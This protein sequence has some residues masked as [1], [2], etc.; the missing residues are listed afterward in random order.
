MRCAN[1]VHWLRCQKHQEVST[2]QIAKLTSRKLIKRTWISWR[3]YSRQNQ[4]Y[5]WKIGV[6][7]SKRQ[8]NTN[9]TSLL[10]SNCQ[11][12]LETIRKK[13]KVVRYQVVLNSMYTTNLQGHIW[14]QIRGHRIATSM[15]AS[16]MEQG[17]QLLRNTRI[18][19]K[20]WSQAK[21]CRRHTSRS[22]QWL[23]YFLSL[24]PSRLRNS[25]N[26]NKYLRVR[27]KI[28]LQMTKIVA[29]LWIYK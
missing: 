3:H 2:F 6:F 12:N 25:E 8:I 11:I 29:S 21:V 18:N 19:Q 22:N 9:A 7:T 28:W 15:R 27:F 17:F 14:I 4:P 16:W 5:H 20:C 10:E 26:Y 24:Q 1:V 13:F 23:T